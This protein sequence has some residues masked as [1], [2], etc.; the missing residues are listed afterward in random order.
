MIKIVVLFIFNTILFSNNLFTPLEDIKKDPSN[1]VVSLGEELFFDKILSKD[2]SVSC[3]SCH[4]MYGADSR[5]ISIGSD[6]K[7]GTINAPSIFNSKYH[8]AYFSN[9]RAKTLKEQMLGPLTKKHEM[10]MDKELI[11]K[12]LNTSTKYKKLF[13]SAYSKNPSFELVIDAIVEFEKTLTTPNSKFDKFL[14]GEAKLSKKEKKGLELFKKYGC[15][16]CH[17]GIN[18][19]SNSFQKFG[20]VVKYPAFK[21]KKNDRYSITKKEKDI[22]VY[23]VASLRNVAKTSPY[24]HTG[25]IDDLKI[26]INI[27]AY[28]NLGKTLKDDEVEAIE[29]FLNTLTGELPKSFLNKRNKD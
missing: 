18:L 19:G 4:Y 20:S 2:R 15:V 29:S 14:K 22:D 6:G 5:Q 9:G 11:E 10:A 27:M 16:T 13:K 12:R 3:Y 23:K 17:N 8:L 25:D 24:F 1:K 26:A 21:T 7:K 28:Y